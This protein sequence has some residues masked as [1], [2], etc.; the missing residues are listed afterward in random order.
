M[1]KKENRPSWFKMFRN[2]KALI[3]SVPDTEVG[4]ALKAV[5]QYFE[6][7]EV[8]EMSPLVFAVFSSV[9]PYIDE[10]FED[11]K[12]NS[13]KNRAN[14]QKRWEKNREMPSDTTGTTCAT[15]TTCTN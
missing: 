11:Y 6:T 13:Q 1:A 7:G 15:R 8:V 9:R 12:A 3:D 10:S 2:Q 4:Q 14:V 5:F